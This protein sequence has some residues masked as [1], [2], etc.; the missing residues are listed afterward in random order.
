MGPPPR[1]GSTG[2]ARLSRGERERLDALAV[3]ILKDHGDLFD[4]DEAGS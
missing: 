3:E 4:T 2:P 1:A